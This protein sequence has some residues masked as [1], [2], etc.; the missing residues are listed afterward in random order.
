METMSDSCWTGR[1]SSGVEGGCAMKATG[2]HGWRA[3]G[4]LALSTVGLAMAG[5]GGN[6]R[7]G[8]VTVSPEA[9]ARLR[10]GPPTPPKAKGK[11]AP[12]TDLR[13]K[14]RRRPEG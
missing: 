13:E 7:E 5:C 11:A 10:A 8:T 6:P 2:R 4:V 12:V 9:R 14:L 3:L 1:G